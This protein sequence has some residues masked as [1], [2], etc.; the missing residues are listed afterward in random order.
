MDG[1]GG[2]EG[3]A[4]GGSPGTRSRRRS[5][6]ACRPP[7][8]LRGHPPAWRPQ[9]NDA[10]ILVVA[11]TDRPYFFSAP[12]GPC[13]VPSTQTKYQRGSQPP[14]ERVVEN[15]AVFFCFIGHVPV[16]APAH[17][18]THNIHILR[19][20]PLQCDPQLRTGHRHHASPP[21]PPRAVSTRPWPPSLPPKYPPFTPYLTSL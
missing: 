1:G 4:E 11:S 6:P 2:N 13:F 20:G 10:S 18:H 3:A 19:I 16:F 5:C 7:F 14:P 12:A 9:R 15:H 17:T 8:H 21:R